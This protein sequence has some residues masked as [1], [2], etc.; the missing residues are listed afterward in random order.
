M[1]TYRGNRGNLMQH[2]VLAELVTS[3][4]DM[5]GSPSE[6]C[7]ID[8]HAMAPFAERHHSPGQ[9][10][11]DFDAVLRALPGQRSPYELTWRTTAPAAGTQYPSSAVF[12]RAI[13]DRSLHLLLCES[14]CETAQTIRAWLGTLD[15]G[16]T[17]HELRHDDWR[18]RFRSGLP[19]DKG[20]YLISFDPY[21]FDQHR[22][23]AK[24]GTMYPSDL[25][26]AGVALLGLPERPTV[27]QLS[28][29]SA[30]NANR[31]YDVV[32]VVEPF[33]TAAG[34][35]LAAEVRAD[36]NMMSLV[37]ARSTPEPFTLCDLPTRFARWLAAV[38]GMSEEIV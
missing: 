35:T 15:V 14:D 12:V 13:W 22:V 21:M 8:A 37:F 5:V 4:R 38:P 32:L 10:A 19:G 20:A 36:G 26:I 18:S 1:P 34:F 3:L 24:P 25:L 31:Q 16:V 11:S 29:Y 6:L 9:T 7:F 27:V 30:N 33:F 28:T 17:S 23:R 2:W